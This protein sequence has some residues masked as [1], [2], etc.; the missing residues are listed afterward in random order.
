MRKIPLAIIIA[1]VAIVLAIGWFKYTVN[2]QVNSERQQDAVAVSDANAGISMEAKD[3]GE[4]ATAR[5][6]KAKHERAVEINQ[7]KGEM[8]GKAESYDSIPLSHSDV[9]ILCRAYR[10]SDPVCAATDK[11]D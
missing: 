10:S 4:Q 1:I 3:K 11:P 9:V 6:D 7:L 8:Y 2:T 5:A